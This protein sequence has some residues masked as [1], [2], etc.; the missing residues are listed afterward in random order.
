MIWPG[1]LAGSVLSFAKGLGEFGAT[2][3]FVSSIPGETR[4][5]PLLIDLALER[6]GGG[7]QVLALSLVALFIAGGALALAEWL[8]RRAAARVGP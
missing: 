1:L 7:G 8:S 5:L 3:T 6:P 2:I 4:T